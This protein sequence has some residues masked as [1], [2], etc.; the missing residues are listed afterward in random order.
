MEVDLNALTP[1]LITKS[2]QGPCLLPVLSVQYYSC[3]LKHGWIFQVVLY[4]ACAAVAR[5]QQLEGLPGRCSERAYILRGPGSF[6]IGMVSFCS[7]VCLLSF[8]GAT[9]SRTV[10]VVPHDQCIHPPKLAL[11]R[12]PVI[13]QQNAAK[14]SRD[15]GRRLLQR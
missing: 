10:A 6:S 2:S 13:A 12:D 9:Q 7:H 1:V 11:W 15:N 14:L 4:C 8:R 3:S 5:V